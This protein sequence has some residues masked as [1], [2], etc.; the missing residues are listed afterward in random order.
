MTPSRRVSGVVGLIDSADSRF[1]AA[2]CPGESPA[3]RLCLS[4]RRPAGHDVSGHAWAAGSR[5]RHRAASTFSGAGVE[6]RV[7]EGIKPMTEKDVRRVAGDG[8][9]KLGEA[10]Q[11]DRGPP[12]DG[13]D[14]A[15][16]RPLHGRLTAT[17]DPPGHQRNRRRCEVTI[18]A[19]AEP[20][21]REMRLETPRG[22]SNPLRFCVGRLPEFREQEPELVTDRQDSGTPDPLP[23]HGHDGHHAAGRR[24]R[25]DHPPRAGRACVSARPVH[26]RRRGPLPLRGPQGPDSWSSPPAA[27]E[28][29]PYLADAVPGWFQA[30]LTLYDA[31]GQESWPTTTTT[32][33]IPIRCSLFK[34]PEDGP[35]VVEIKDAIYRGRPDFVYRITIGELPFVTSIFPLG[36]RAGAQTTVETERAGTCPATS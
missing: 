36:G 27:R 25:A 4:G 34:V 18:A 32:A 3:P 21:R 15:K 17:A 22:M 11:K 35:Y 19:D 28:L 6:A 20:G 23:G 8:S 1:S 2:L 29:I 16:A 10:S 5:T 31:Q 30:T 7:V 12:G 26:A 13:R 24:Q 14:P 33:S 9:R